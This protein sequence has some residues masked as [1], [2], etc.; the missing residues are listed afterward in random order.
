M[1]IKT[2]IEAGQTDLSKI[3][4]IAAGSKIPVTFAQ[5]L[6]QRGYRTEE[7]VRSFL[8]PDESCLH[9]PFAMKDMDKAV[10]RI[11]KALSENEKILIYGDYDADGI[12]GTA[13]LVRYLRTRGAEPL[14]HIPDRLS[15]GYGVNEEA[16]LGFAK[17]QVK[18]MITVDTGST[19]A[20]EIA[21]AADFGIDTVVTD[22]HECHGELPI[23]CALVNPMRPDCDYPFKGLS[24]VGVAF[25]LLCALESAR[26]PE[27]E[28]GEIF[29]HVSEGYADIAALG[30]IGDV[31]PLIDENRYI[32]KTGL[33]CL[34]KTRFPGLSS[35]LAQ[36]KNPKS[37][38]NASFVSFS[39]VPKINAAGRMGNAYTALELFL[40]DDI[41]A[42]GRIAERLCDLNSARQKEEQHI[43]AQAENMLV[44]GDFEKDPILVLGAEGWHHGVLGIVAS[45]ILEKYKKTTFLLTYDG[46]FC[47]G[48]G[49]GVEGCNLVELLSSGSELLE[50]FG[51]HEAA[52][53]L[54]LKKEN[55]DLFR[56]RI[57]EAAVD[58]LGDRAFGHDRYV[59]AD[60]ALS[61]FEMTLPFAESLQLLEPCGNG[62]PL[63]KFVSYDMTVSQ[64]SPLSGGKHAKPILTKDGIQFTSLIFGTAPEALPFCQGDTVDALFELSVNEYAGRKSLQLMLKQTFL[65]GGAALA[66]ERERQAYK[67]TLENPPLA[68]RR[69]VPQREDFAVIYRYLRGLEERGVHRVSYRCM[70]YDCFFVKTTVLC[71]LVCDIFEEVGLLRRHRAQSNEET[72]AFELVKTGEKIN[73]ERSKLWGALKGTESP[74]C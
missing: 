1:I 28:Q 21:Y 26:N 35:L 31:M 63:P 25:K 42:A 20:K 33:R 41:S 3:S 53:G 6:Y 29:K 17:A 18:L 47:K 9:S 45:R 24:G 61:P 64:V 32:V 69:F 50:K 58:I 49:R 23:C 13:L 66:E 10:E 8:N 62:N 72:A 38:L 70:A 59:E 67:Q 46:E 5:I 12:S 4:E 37:V 30:T 27:K 68:E 22:H 15:D 11:E 7:Q 55:L 48:S 73:L 57:N 36:V 54:S 52:A 74:I 43:L 71:R 65:S 51:G 60:M 44:S 34:E 39:I 2:R 56:R 19:A 40:T 16:V 14:Y